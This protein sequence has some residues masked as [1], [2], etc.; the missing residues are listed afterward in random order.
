MRCCQSSS[1]PVVQERPG[2]PPQ[3][4]I[5][6]SNAARMNSCSSWRHHRAKRQD[7]EGTGRHLLVLPRHQVAARRAGVDGTS[8]VKMGEKPMPLM[9]VMKFGKGEVLD[10]HRGD[11]ALGATRR[12]QVFR[13]VLV[14][15][16]QPDGLPHLQGRES[17]QVQIASKG[18][19]SLQSARYGH[20]WLYNEDRTPYLAKE[21]VGHAQLD[22]DSPRQKPRTIKL[23]PV[24]DETGKAIQDG[25]Y[26]FQLP[27]DK[28]GASRSG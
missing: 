16:G 25:Y 6:L 13:P 28:A 7:L 4:R 19:S 5:Q 10:G 27:H 15:G 21:V 22:G 18:E 14:A 24:E 23:K 1:C 11:V 20:A 3:F 2:S 17:Q 26:Q 9:A 12:G 8:K